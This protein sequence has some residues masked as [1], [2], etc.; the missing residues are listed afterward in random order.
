M[1]DVFV[2][3]YTTDS[4]SFKIP[5]TE[6][7]E[8]ADDITTDSVLVTTNKKI[9]YVTVDLSTPESER[10]AKVTWTRNALEDTTFDLQGEMLEG[11]GYAIAVKQMKVI[12]AALAAVSGSDMASGAIVDLSATLTW[13]EFLS[14][15]GAVDVG[16][17]Q[18]DSTYKT[19]GPADYCLVSPD[20]Y[21]KL[22]NII[23]LTNVLYE[24]STDPVKSGTIKLAL[25]TTIVKM[26]LLPEGTMYAL[27]SE[28]AICNVIKRT[29]KLEPIIFPE[30][31]RYGFVGTVRFQPAVIYKA[32][33]QKGSVSGS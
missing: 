4:T 13:E 16:V 30:Q 10:G 23:Q 32:A 9:D 33:I 24:G 19:Y 27:N 8:L 25:G 26:S 6:Y 7:Q 15:V 1:S 31:N 14:V 11:L 20:I 22:L 5:L 12:L 17:K 18:D 21:W 3:K 28:K 29:L 2:K